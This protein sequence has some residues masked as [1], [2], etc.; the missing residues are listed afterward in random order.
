MSILTTW[1]ESLAYD[2]E[3][4]S[5]CLRSQ[6]PKSNCAECLPYCPENAISFSKQGAERDSSLCTNCGHCVPVCP[7]QAITGRSP[8]R[9]IVNETLLI[10]DSPFPSVKELLYFYKRGV[11][12]VN[13]DS[14]ASPD[15]HILKEADSLLT[16][17]G[18]EPFTIVDSIPVYNEEPTFTR[19]SFFIKAA[20]EGK[21]IA[22]ATITPA[23]WRFN[24]NQFEIT[25]MFPGYA[26]YEVIID[27]EQCNL[28]EA[29]FKM[30]PQQV[31]SLKE[32]L[33]SVNSGSCN[34]CSLCVDICGKDAIK[35]V[36]RAYPSQ[37]MEL[38]VERLTCPDCNT[39]F[40]T[41]KN[42]NVSSP[43]P[44]CNICDTRSKNGYFSPYSV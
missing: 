2:V 21:K 29:C 37:P 24:Q 17:M 23:K 40:H 14:T 11:R 22:A 12:N 30:C 15:I 35:I 43:G 42:P 4:S 20:F 28:C 41:W 32:G 9:K 44:L 18:Y 3:I 13:C 16:A 5:A 19:R 10:E 8:E 25:S 33:L 26:V 27:Q 6:S 31:F 39:P 34:G 36:Q 38:A 1:L 7:V